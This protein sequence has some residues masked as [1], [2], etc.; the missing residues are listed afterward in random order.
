MKT[1]SLFL[2]ISI[3]LTSNIVMSQSSIEPDKRLKAIYSETDL[4]RM[5][6]HNPETID[7]LNFQ[8]DNSWFIAGEEILP[9]VQDAP[10]LYYLDKETGQASDIRVEQIDPNNLNVAEFYIEK[11]FNR[12]VFYKVGNSGTIIGFYSTKEF[13]KIYNNYKSR[14]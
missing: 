10:Y 9:K 7:L 14:Q 13:A 3:I 5:Q 8:L 6:T 11:D 12:H 2:F 1:L 4:I